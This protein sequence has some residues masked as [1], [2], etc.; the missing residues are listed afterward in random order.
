MIPDKAS[1]ADPSFLP[2]EKS[3]FNTDDTELTE[4]A[5]REWKEL[6]WVSAIEQYYPENLS[7]FSTI[8]P[9]DINGGTL[10]QS[11]YFQSALAAI[12]TNPRQVKKMFVDKPLKQGQYIFNGYFNGK[13]MSI[14]LDDYIPFDN[15]KDLPAFT[16]TRSKALWPIFAEKAWAKVNG[17]YESIKS[18]SISEALRFLTASPFT[19]TFVHNTV[20]I[21][22]FWY[23]L[24]EALEEKHLICANTEKN[25]EDYNTLESNYSYPVLGAREAL[26][27]KNRVTLLHVSNPWK[28]NEWKGD[29]SK[30]SSTWTEEA[31]GVLGKKGT[32]GTDRFFIS[33]KDYLSF[34]QSTTI[35][36]LPT[37]S[38]FVK[39]IECTQA[40]GDF[41]LIEI[42]TKDPT[43]GFFTIAQKPKR[44]MAKKYINYKISEVSLIIAK[45][46]NSDYKFIKGLINNNENCT[47]K[48]D[49][50]AT[51]D[52]LIF[53]EINW[54]CEGVD[55]FVFNVYTSRQTEVRKI[56]SRKYPN[57]IEKVLKSC[58]ILKTE[59]KTYS[60]KHEP[61]IKKYASI[62]G[63]G[64][65]YGYL[66]YKNDSESSILHESLTFKKLKNLTTSVK[67][68]KVDIRLNPNQDK[69]II[70]KKT[71]PMGK[72]SLDKIT[73][74]RFT[75]DKLLQ[76]LKS[77]GTEKK[78][79]EGDVSITKLNHDFGN[80]WKCKNNSTRTYFGAKFSFNL[81]NLKFDQDEDPNF[82]IELPPGEEI[83]KF[84][85]KTSETQRSMYKY[86]Y[87]PYFKDPR[88]LPDEE[89]AIE[90]KRSS[91]IHQLQNKNELIPVQYYTIYRNGWYYWYFINGSKREFNAHL[92]FTLN[93]L[94]LIDNYDNEWQISLESGEE[95]IKHLRAVDYKQPISYQVVITLT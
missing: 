42:Q 54:C 70:L 36:Y 15:K 78:L 86:T 33:F 20:D 6:T 73:K 2:S 34:Y 11:Y 64:A 8:D 13:Q 37:N 35:C 43:N 44:L 38:Q 26:I 80:V 47:I 55:T 77:N 1:F 82:D 89:A 19:T 49:S 22:Q 17:N 23:E 87:T 67:G 90:I 16:R 79:P 63:S 61:M 40:P 95:V 83:I 74:L 29:W 4:A 14:E 18:G 92:E 45:K 66:Y 51:K 85:W 25:P 91:E 48:L 21:E 31:I 12:A 68:K 58:A 7:L 62:N 10:L 28:V 52:T 53:I 60:E 84:L 81:Q 5:A 93:N 9:L 41:S 56:S 30:N 32:E 88:P 57:F 39:E 24:N 46:E 3:L 75:K 50:T 27:D 72:Y 65:G 76:L 59:P 71:G 94:E 69:I